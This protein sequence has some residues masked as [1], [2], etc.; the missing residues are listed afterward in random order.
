MR[1]RT[2]LFSESRLQNRWVDYSK[3]NILMKEPSESADMPKFNKSK[4]ENSQT[5][6]NS[7]KQKKDLK[8]GGVIIDDVDVDF[9]N[10][11]LNGTWFPL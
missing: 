9:E 7:Q 8:G 5:L 10:S 4:S 3:M 2:V 6:I 1:E 11:Y